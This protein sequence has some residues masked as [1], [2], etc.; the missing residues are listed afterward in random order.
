MNLQINSQLQGGKYR[1]E[2][3]L[4]QGGFGITYL[5][6]QVG[7]NRKV[8][9]KE[10]FMKEYC[11]RDEATSSVSLGTV[12]SREVVMRFRE[13]FTKEAQ[14]IAA[15]NHPHIIR[16]YDVFEE[17][18]TAYYVMEYLDNASL[19]DYLKQKG[20]LP[21]QE[22]VRFIKQIA[23]ALAYIHEHKI[24][25]LDVKP[26]NIL[27]DNKNNAVLIDFGLAKRYD[28]AGHQ[29]ST[30]PVGISH[31]YAPL[32]QYKQ[33]GVGT[34]SPT[35]D[36]YSL[37]ATLYKL[38]TGQTPPDAGDV[39]EDGLPPF[40][41]D[42]SQPTINAITKAMQGSR[43]NRPQ[44]I[45][46]FLEILDG[47]G[48]GSQGLKV[49]GSQRADDEETII[50]VDTD[51][52]S[53][54]G[55]RTQITA[56][57]PKETAA[58]KT[59]EAPKKKKSKAW[60]FILL[61]IILGGAGFYLFNKERLFEYKSE[62]ESSLTSDNSDYREEV[63]ESG[64]DITELAV[65]IPEELLPEEWV[66]LTPR[67][68]EQDNIETVQLAQAQ[69]EAEAKA[70]AE[71]EKKKK[72]EEARLK[73]EQERLEKERKELEAQKAEQARL[74]KE[75]QEREAAEVFTS[76]EEMPEFPYGAARMMEYIQK[77]I[78]Y[79]IEARESNVEGRVYVNFIVETD[80]SISNVNVLRGIG[81]GCDEE[82]MRVVRGMPKWK[83]GKHNGSAVRVSYTIPIIFK[84]E[85]TSS[86]NGHYNGHEYV[87]LGLSVKW[88]TCNVG[89]SKPED[90]GDYYAWGETKTKSEY[91][92]DN[93]VTNGKSFSDI[94]GDSR[95][96]AARANWG[97]SWRLPTKKEY[98]E[99]V[100]K[101]NW[102]WTVQNGKMGYKVTGPNGNSIF[103]PAAGY[104]SGSSLYGAGSFGGY[105]SSTPY[106]SNTNFAYYLLFDSGNHFVNW[107][108]RYGGRSVR[109]VI[110]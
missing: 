22:A 93:S 68:N 20:R 2:K 21:E 1:I 72:E 98:E 60:I 38:V 32:E 18:N 7:L 44:N 19:S 110:E 71:A 95:Y 9:I 13:K 75:R 48:L 54:T 91:W 100:N 36:I 69:K 43:K 29:T 89:A 73:A 96:D 14:N 85:E 46:D 94:K 42:I 45:A 25:H 103:L 28:E 84:L 33:G 102:T 34:F 77:N 65:E 24:N 70:Q 61:A 26:G 63:V 52:N 31:G 4:G 30:T 107:G 53:D 11:N 51:T 101:C 67:N 8:A 49:A 82:A 88:A 79:P 5:A 17:N 80:G 15:L 40:P 59:P 90:Y 50:D 76:V 92:D 78:E 99:L 87:D 66:E 3:I 6:T 97:G 62:Y 83:P 56:S 41:T 109:P 105:W 35:T 39:N 108:Y 81:G 104:R 64:G 86:A 27:L 74:E 58:P 106:E 10:F 12:G 47:K 16:I 23:D 37:A 57:S 55:K